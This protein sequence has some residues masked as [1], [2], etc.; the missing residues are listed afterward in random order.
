MGSNYQ[1][2]R[3]EDNRQRLAEQT[4]WLRRVVVA[5]SIL[6]LLITRSTGYDMMTTTPWLRSAR[7]GRKIALGKANRQPPSV[8]RGQIEISAKMTSMSPLQRQLVDSEGN[9]DGQSSNNQTGRRIAY[10][11]QNLEQHL[12]EIYSLSLDRNN[13]CT[14]CNRSFDPK[15]AILG[16]WRHIRTH[17]ADRPHVCR[18]C[19]KSFHQID[20]LN[21]HMRIHQ[22]IKPFRCKVCNRNF[23][24]NG[25]LRTHKRR[26]DGYK[27]FQCH[28]C[29][30]SFHHKV[31]MVAH[32]HKHK[33]LPPY[34]CTLCGKTFFQK[35]NM[36]THLRVRHYQLRIFP[37]PK[38]N[39]FFGQATQLEKHLGTHSTSVYKCDKCGVKFARRHHLSRHLNIFEKKRRGV[40]ACS[41]CNRNYSM[42]HHLQ[43]HMRR[44]LNKSDPFFCPACNRTFVLKMHYYR[45][46]GK[47]SSCLNAGKI[48]EPILPPEITSDQEQE[49]DQGHDSDRVEGA[50]EV[51]SE[52]GEESRHYKPDKDIEVEIERKSL[53]TQEV[54]M[55]QKRRRGRPP[56]EKTRVLEDVASELN[57]QVLW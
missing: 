48:P 30:L 19:N 7:N 41:I 3:E 36:Q 24:Q 39:K 22:G 8:S 35:S 10:T 37:C 20:N 31:S 18:L 55:W 4:R 51:N 15:F 9:E 54:I 6:L 21:A 40:Y 43:N 5:S 47:N 33:G 17:A 14:I 46:F 52:S 13:T 42:L 38:C 11:S 45:H 2:Q 25:H 56:Y 49:Q 1:D 16:M 44:H 12:R 29:G 28:I 27:P 53:V 23:T 34:N 50:D 32:V 57:P 26:H